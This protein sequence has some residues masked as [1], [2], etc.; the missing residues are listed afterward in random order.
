MAMEARSKFPGPK[1]S[2]LNIPVLF[3]K[4]IRKVT[5][6]IAVTFIINDS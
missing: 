2:E 1:T 4:L 5:V 6:M 3:T